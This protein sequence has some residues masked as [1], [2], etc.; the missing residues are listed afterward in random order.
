MAETTILA[1]ETAFFEKN[2]SRFREQ[3]RDRYLLIHGPELIGDFG[4][5]EEAVVAG[6][7]RFGQG[8]FL[9]RRPGDPVPVFD[10]PAYSMG[11]LHAHYQS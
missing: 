1:E 6:V 3:Y 2:E 11:L 5:E 8:P 7:E 4:D 9:V 10:A